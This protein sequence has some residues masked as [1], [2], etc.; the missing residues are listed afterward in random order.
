MRSGFGRVGEEAVASDP[1][2]PL[3]GRGARATADSR[4]GRGATRV[5][6]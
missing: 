4:C 3:V 5:N 1:D 6:F 2:E